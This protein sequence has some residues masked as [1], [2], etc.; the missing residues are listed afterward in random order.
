MEEEYLETVAKGYGDG[1]QSRRGIDSICV[2]FAQLVQA[3]EETRADVLGDIF[4][5]G[6][7]YGEAGQFLTPECITEL[8]LSLTANREPGQTLYDPC[9]GSGR[10][11]LAREGE[12]RPWEVVGQD[13]DLRCVKMTGLNLALR[14]QY[15]LV[16]WGNTLANE[17]KK[18]YRTGFHGRGFIREIPVE[19]IATIDDQPRPGTLPMPAVQSSIE[20]EDEDGPRRQLDLF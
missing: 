17:V 15:G 10:M 19:Q 13:V 14:N 3:M 11:L 18:A 6:I 7:T 16:L 12:P 20:R 5:G 9:C 4:E 8:M 2:A 1:E